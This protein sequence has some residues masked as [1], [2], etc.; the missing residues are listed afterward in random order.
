[1]IALVRAEELEETPSSLLPV[2]PLRQNDRDLIE[3]WLAWK[4]RRVSFP[5]EDIVYIDSPAI[6]GSI[7]KV[8]TS[9]KTAGDA[10]QTLQAFA[11]RCP[12]PLREVGLVGDPGEL[13][14]FERG[15]LRREIF[16]FA[17][18]YKARMAWRLG[19]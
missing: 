3:Q 8:F 15:A 7:P 12:V 16:L 1:M 6:G 4:R 18:D 2:H 19:A 13:V 5:T 11:K 10:R 14:A 17:Q 9:D